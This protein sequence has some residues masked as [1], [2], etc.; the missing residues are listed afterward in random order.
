MANIRSIQPINTSLTQHFVQVGRSRR[1]G[2][3]QL[4]DQLK[5]TGR[6][7]GGL[8]GLNVYSQ[9]YVGGLD[10]FIKE[11]LPKGVDFDS[12]IIGEQIF[13]LS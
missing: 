13:I 1:D 2:W 4:D 7:Q 8:V 11:D 12:G 5:V 9:L 10:F 6:S 3:L